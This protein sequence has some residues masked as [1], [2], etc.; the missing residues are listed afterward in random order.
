M[1]KPN[2]DMRKAWDGLDGDIWAAAAD[3]YETRGAGHRRLLLHAA[4]IA[5]GER[6]LDLGCGN[7]ASTREAAR[8]AEPGEVVGIDLSTAMLTNARARSAAAGLTNVS[9]VHGDAQ[10]HDFGPESFDVIISNAGAMFFDDKVAAFSNL[11]R[12][13]RPGGRIVLMA[14]QLL[15]D[16]EWLTV[17][18]ETLAMGR[19]L[20]APAVGMPG[21]FGLSDRDQ[22][23][24]LLSA[25]G[26]TDVGFADVREPMVCG[27]TT[28]EAYALLSDDGP[29]RGLLADLSDADK[30]TALDKLRAVIAAHETPTG[31]IFGS[32]SWLIQARRPAAE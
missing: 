4:A 31:V 10:V 11:R 29:V 3:Q 5:S 14:W 16:N 30:A 6:V 21:P 9:F 20:P 12:A 15:E 19:D 22:V 32:A 17:L 1:S 7:G 25:T 26:F 2:A 24:A 23:S 27:A 13:L 28:D 8:M 18:R